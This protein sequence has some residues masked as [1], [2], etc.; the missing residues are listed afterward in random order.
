MKRM[1]PAHRLGRPDNFVTSK[2]RA[3]YGTNNTISQILL[4]AAAAKLSDADYPRIERGR[5][6]KSWS[7]LFL[8]KT[9]LQKF[10]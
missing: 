2:L 4:A 8:K 5:Q 7:S 3:K 6:R 9:H 1:I 10:T